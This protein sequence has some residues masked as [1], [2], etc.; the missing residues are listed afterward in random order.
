MTSEARVSENVTALSE[1]TLPSNN[2][3][4]GLGQRMSDDACLLKDHSLE[5]NPGAAA[6]LVVKAFALSVDP[7]VLEDLLQ[8]WVLNSFE[9]SEDPQGSCPP[10]LRSSLGSPYGHHQNG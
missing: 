10:F 8:A 1:A 6:G 9:D 3:H 7:Q 2:A 4:L 5:S